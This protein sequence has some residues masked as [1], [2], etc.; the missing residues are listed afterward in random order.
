M[1]LMAGRPPLR[2]GTHGRIRR[3]Y[4]AKDR[5][6]LARCRFHD[7]DGVVR[8]VER[9]GPAGG[10]DEYGNL[11]EGALIEALAQRRPPSRGD[12]TPDTKIA[13]LV[14]RHIDKLEG[15][16]A[17]ATIDTY[18]VTA[19]KLARI[20]GHVRL[21]DATA[22]R[23]DEAL[24]DVREKHG[25]GMARHARAVLRGAFHLAVLAE[26]LQRN[27]MR[28]VSDIESAAPPKGA[29]PLTG[30]QVRDL[31]GKLAASQFC[32]EH[33]LVDPIVML[34]ATGLRRSELLG[35]RWRD[36][37]QAAETI[38]VTG[39][40]A[41]IKGQG[42]QRFD[43]T[44][45]RAGARTLPL[46]GFAVAMLAQRRK[47]PFL[48]DRAMIFPSAAGTFRDPNNFG[49]DWR[50][51][52]ESLDVPDVTTHSFRK[53]LATLIDAEGLTARMG[54]D[55]LGHAKVSMTQDTYMARNRVHVEVADM[56]DR[57]VKSDE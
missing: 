18:R 49:R 29:P 56:L 31:L 48:G 3:V 24:Q 44:K 5:V 40:V 54:A 55:H 13:A 12:I 28:E 43:A 52:R 21:R 27:P 36:Y 4:V 53:T 17:A 35:L 50:T 37:D 46:P 19:R 41:R 9:R 26:V 23:M 7:S 39:K 32:Q 34:I 15:R 45:T 20:A 25:A 38:A 8:I 10:A 30:K 14:D 51:V 6:W 16:R 2:P 1:G 22:G 47:R 42:L 11:A 33:D 57:V